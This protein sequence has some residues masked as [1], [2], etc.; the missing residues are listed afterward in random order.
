MVL[1]PRRT[2]SIPA[3]NPTY[4][5]V[6][7]IRKALVSNTLKRE[8]GKREYSAH[9]RLAS[10]YLT[11]VC[12][13]QDAESSDA[14]SATKRTTGE[15]K[16]LISDATTS[17]K[18]VSKVKKEDTP[19]EKKGIKLTEND[20]ADKVINFPNFGFSISNYD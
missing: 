20:E 2:T 4:F 6:S 5:G 14:T 16:S 18:E 17:D 13:F 11:I 8:H 1:G 9:C 12:L 19:S 7:L 10:I 15:E 3:R